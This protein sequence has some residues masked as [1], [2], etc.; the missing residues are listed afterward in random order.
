[1][2]GKGYT[3][4]REYEPVGIVHRGEFYGPC[5]C[6]GWVNA[7]LDGEIISH[8]APLDPKVKHESFGVSIMFGKEWY[9]CKN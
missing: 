7:Y 2:T 3:G 8:S 5:S 4:T 9:D 1:M 6:G